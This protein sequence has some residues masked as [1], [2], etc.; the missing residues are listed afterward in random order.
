MKRFKH[1]VEEIKQEAIL[2]GADN[3]HLEKKL[4]KVNQL[5]VLVQVG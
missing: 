5:F 3:K 2:T 4:D 1:Y